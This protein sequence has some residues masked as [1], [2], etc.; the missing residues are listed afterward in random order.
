MHPGN[1]GRRPW[2][3]DPL[4]G[5]SPWPTLGLERSGVSW[6]AGSGLFYWF[7]LRL[8]AAA[9]HPAC[10]LNVHSK[11]PSVPAATSCPV[12]QSESI[13]LFSSQS[14]RSLFVVLSL[15]LVFFRT[16]DLDRSN[17]KNPMDACGRTNCRSC[18]GNVINRHSWV[19][20]CACIHRCAYSS[21]HVNKQRE[22]HSVAIRASSGCCELLLGF[23][24]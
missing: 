23:M 1:S 14:T 4:R 22:F 9:R 12:F 13:H 3:F 20:V 15:F 2:I 18:P 24:L 17:P 11:G 5:A 8:R 6:M 16:A 21:G 19:F 7:N 10:N